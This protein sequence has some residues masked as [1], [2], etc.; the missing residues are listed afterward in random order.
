MTYL[1][2]GFIAGIVVGIGGLFTFSLAAISAEADREIEAA[3]T[4]SDKHRVT[5]QL[6]RILQESEADRQA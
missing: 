5:E 6:Y 3:R 4:E 2:M 1:V